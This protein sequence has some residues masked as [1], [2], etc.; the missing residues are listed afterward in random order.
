MALRQ[1]LTFGNSPQIWP[2]SFSA[3][4]EELPGLIVSILAVLALLF[5]GRMLRERSERLLELER[6]NQALRTEIAERK[7]TEEALI[8][9]E[10]LFRITIDQMPAAV[11]LKDPEGRYIV[12]NQTFQNWFNPQKRNLS[13]DTVWNL[14][15][16]DHA[17]EILAMEQAVRD[18]QEPLTREMEVPVA[19]QGWRRAFIH[20]FPLFD[21]S[22][23]LSAIGT[24]ET[25]N[26][27]L[28]EAEARLRQAQ[29]M[30]AV[31]QLTGGV[32]H[33]FNNLLAVIM[34]NTEI[35]Q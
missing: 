9:S 4:I 22:G 17:T 16:E 6:A 5:L 7:Q 31:G 23:S 18:S 10:S 32:A 15:P 8:Q 30:E 28:R 12:V 11:S 3:N 24:I 34:G 14:V 20:K 26:T 27:D 13:I 29:K 33:D 21:A 19:G 2:L 1:I 35:L 25:D